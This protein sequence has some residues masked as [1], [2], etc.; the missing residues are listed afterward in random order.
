M[1]SWDNLPSPHLTPMQTDA[2]S[3][4]DQLPG[5]HGPSPR[6]ARSGWGSLAAVAIVGSIVLWC[7]P[8]SLLVLHAHPSAVHPHSTPLAQC[9][10]AQP[11]VPTTHTDLWTTLTALH[12]TD[13]FQMRAVQGLG[14]AVRIPTETFDAMGPVGEDPRWLSRAPFSGH[15]EAAYPKAHATLS[16]QRVNTYGLVYTWTGSDPSLKPLL[17]MGHYDVVPVAPLS[18]D[19]WTHP[20]YSGYF[21]GES[22]WGRG[23]SDDKSGVIGIMTTIE[24]LLEH[25]FVPRR[26]IVLSF[27][28]DE[29]AGG[30]HGAGHL[31]PA[32]LELYGPDSFAMIVDEG[33]GFSD[34]YGAIFAVPGVAEKGSITVELEVKT[35]GGH[36]S[37]PPEHTSIGVLAAL[38]VELENNPPPAKFE[39]DSTFFQMTAC[40]A[41]HGPDIDTDLR[42]A[43]LAS[44]SNE[45]ARAEAERILSKN[46]TFRS[47]FGTTQ[48]VDIV[49]G[50]VKSNALPEQAV[51]YINHR[52]STKS[53]V[54]ETVDRDRTILAPVIEKYDL[55]GG[56]VELRSPGGLEPAPITPS[57]GAA[58]ELLSGTIR[59][60]F[61]KWHDG[62]IYVAPGMMTGNTDTRFYWDLSKHIFRYGHNNGIGK[63][64]NGMGGIH[65]VN[66]HMSASA[67]IEM[68]TFFTTLVLNLDEA[69]L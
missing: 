42:A 4:F 41:S 5:A 20:A 31:G 40:Y 32:L 24:T 66:E 2:K 57:D 25:G 33:S 26:S 50:G 18:V 21:D 27:G 3:H 12:H 67:F 44:P 45:S 54:A 60:A 30:I 63:G 29:E 43:I 6:K 11:L 55:G 47:L 62:E 64:D 8:S 7:K 17:L 15:L 14:A 10:Q 69:A 9:P 23:S 16:L 46:K 28:F 56:S 19:Q 61:L 59:A 39:T 35:P 22:V 13:A 38:I 49:S 34:Q 51:A 1:R 58:F 36:S 37:V 52:I 68:I 48:A 65:T 53:S